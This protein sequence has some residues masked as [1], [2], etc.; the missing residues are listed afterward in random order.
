M[1]R[2]LD[3][4]IVAIAGQQQ[5]IREKPQQLGKIVAAA[6][7]EIG[8]GLVNQG[9]RNRGCSGQLRVGL[10]GAADEQKM[11]A[12]AAGKLCQSAEAKDGLQAA[13]NADDDHPLALV[14]AGQR[15][16][17]MLFRGDLA[18][19]QSPNRREVGRQSRQG[20]AKR[21][22]IGVGVRQQEN[23][24]SRGQRAIVASRL[25]RPRLFAERSFLP[26]PW[27]M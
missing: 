10:A 12:T 7:L 13:Q 3:G 17:Q 11:L 15:G 24:A 6:S 23:A 20:T 16:S 22:Q 2:V 19:T 18:K 8:S 25:R 21:E 4:G 5:V 14:R 9:R 26:V 1:L 27:L